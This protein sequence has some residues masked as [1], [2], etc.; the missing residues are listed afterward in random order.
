MTAVERKTTACEPSQPVFWRHRNARGA[1][2]VWWEIF[3]S[4]LTPGAASL[5]LP[6]SSLTL[7]RYFFSLF[8]YNS[9]SKLFSLAFR[10]LTF[11]G[12]SV[13]LTHSFRLFQSLPLSLSLTLSVC[14]SVCLFACWSVCL[15]IW[16]FISIRIFYSTISYLFTTFNFQLSLTLPVNLRDLILSLLSSKYMT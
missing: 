15:S 7:L 11:I 8:L 9:Y 3:H 13:S 1:H 4:R 5:S 16:H 6:L 14:V 12:L 10:Y 2:R